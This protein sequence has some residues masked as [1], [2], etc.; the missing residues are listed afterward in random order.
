MTSFKSTLYLMHLFEIQ[1][2]NSCLPV[3]KGFLVLLLL[4]QLKYS[5]FS[6]KLLLLL[7]LLFWIKSF[8]FTIISFSCKFL[9]FCYNV[10]STFHPRDCSK[11]LL[12]LI[13]NESWSCCCLER[14]KIAMNIS[15]LKYNPGIFSFR[16]CLATHMGICKT[17]ERTPER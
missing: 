4:Q 9:A 15:P 5:L 17:L 10:A 3:L 13:F 7:L 2:R 11:S 6:T 14:K 12:F 16:S 1:S 8:I